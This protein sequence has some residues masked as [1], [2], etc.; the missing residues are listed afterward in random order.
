MG[1]S[2]VELSGVSFTFHATVAQDLVTG[3]LGLGRVLR[4]RG[5]CDEEHRNFGGDLLEGL[6]IGGNLEQRGMRDHAEG[7][8]LLDCQSHGV[9]SLKDE[10]LSQFSNRGQLC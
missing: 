7:D 3:L 9:L 8:S 5:A 4:V 2:I 1:A 10:V 6:E